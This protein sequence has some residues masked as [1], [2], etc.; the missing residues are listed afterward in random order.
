MPTSI[1]LPDYAYVENLTDE[2]CQKSKCSQCSIDSLPCHKMANLYSLSVRLEPASNLLVLSKTIKTV[3]VTK[4]FV[5]AGAGGVGGGGGSASSRAGGV[6]GTTPAVEFKRRRRTPPPHSPPSAGDVPSPNQGGISQCFSRT[7]VC[8]LPC[9]SMHKLRNFL[10][11]S[12]LLIIQHQRSILGLREG[13]LSSGF[14]SHPTTYQ[15]APTVL[16]FCTKLV[17]KLN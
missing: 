9:C 1:T 10:V 8:L 15:A 11:I 6:A 3:R 16:P 5:G 2:Q 13:Y 4:E 12:G 17:Q 7:Q 14:T